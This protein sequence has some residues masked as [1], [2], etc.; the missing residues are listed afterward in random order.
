MNKNI[1]ESINQFYNILGKKKYK[2]LTAIDNQITWEIKLLCDVFENN[3][4]GILL[5]LGCGYGRLSFP[6]VEKGFCVDGIDLCNSFISDAKQKNKLLGQNC[7]FFLGDFC[8]YEFTKT[9]NGIFCM[10][11]TIRHVINEKKQLNFYKK[12]FDLLDSNGSLLFTLADYDRIS[13]FSLFQNEFIERKSFNKNFETIST[14]DQKDYGEILLSNMNEKILTS[15]L[16]TAG[17]KTIKRIEIIEDF[18]QLVLL[19]TK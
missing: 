16:L 14:V 13:D 10:S 11:G 2:Y 17:F 3:K 19:A 12:L 6:L 15:Y 4:D 7:N 9:Y 5:D 18:S 1:N 8:T